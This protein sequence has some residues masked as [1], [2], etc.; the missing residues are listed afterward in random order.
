MRGGGGGGANAP[1]TLTVLVL[2]EQVE[3]VKVERIPRAGSR[4][5]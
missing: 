2:E 4:N 5:S 1:G 3:V